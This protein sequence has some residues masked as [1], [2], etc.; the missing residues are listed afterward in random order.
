[1][2]IPPAYPGRSR[3]RSSPPF[4]IALEGGIRSIETRLEWLEWAAGQLATA[5]QM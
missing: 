4:G 2:L 5:S 3:R 1:V